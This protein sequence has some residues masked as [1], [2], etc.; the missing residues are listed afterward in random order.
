MARAVSHKGAIKLAVLC[1]LIALAGFLGLRAS[2]KALFARESERPTA[3]DN[4]IVSL[5]DHSTMVA[6]R[7]TLR[8][9]MI[10]WFNDDTSAT[11]AFGLTGETFVPGTDQL[12]PDAMVKIGRFVAMLRA[13]RDVKARIRVFGNAADGTDMRLAVRRAERL[14]TGIAAQ[15]IQASRF[16][17][18]AEAEA[19]ALGNAPRPEQPTHL[20]I[21]LSR[22]S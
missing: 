8:R 10:D 6:E 11:H 22:S 12:T 4:S 16:I 3:L 15:G 5:K 21:I 19:S 14:R 1:L 13:N 20:E 18:V 9:E 2:Y 7:G 17:V